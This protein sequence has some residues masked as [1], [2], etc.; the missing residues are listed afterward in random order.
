MGRLVR[1]RRKNVSSSE[2]LSHHWASRRYSCGTRPG[3][4]PERQKGTRSPRDTVRHRC[5]AGQQPAAADPNASSAG[6]KELSVDL[7]AKTKRSEGVGLGIL[8]GITQD[9]LQPSDEFL[10]PLKINAFRSGGWYAGG[11]IKDK[12][13]FG[14]GTQAN[15]DAV[16]AEAKRLQRPPRQK[17]E[18]QVLLS[19]VFGS[20]GG[21][22]AN[23][24][25]P[26]TD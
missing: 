25:W 11:W 2:T 4:G 14:P 16:I 24:L 9:G 8:Y 7:S 26:C 12:Y 13:T 1:E 17:V 21:A 3:P 6:V 18:Y 19:D 23:T 15:I 5:L 10:E 22:P 20:T